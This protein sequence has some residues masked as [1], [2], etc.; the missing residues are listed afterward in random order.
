MSRMKNKTKE[1]T[2]D[3]TA[4]ALGCSP[5]NV[6]RVLA[7]HRVKPIRHGHRTVGIPADVVARLVIK[8]I[9]KNGN[10]HGHRKA[11]R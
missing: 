10:G 11:S 5:R 6:R 3:Q 4:K 9:T 7:R 2:Y 1:L 8:T